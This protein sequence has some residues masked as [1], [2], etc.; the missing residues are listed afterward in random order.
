[1]PRV[2]PSDLTL[3][4]FKAISEE[5]STREI[6]QSVVL[7]I[8]VFRAGTNSV[9]GDLFLEKLRKSIDSLLDNDSE[10]LRIV[11]VAAGDVRPNQ[12]DLPQAIYAVALTIS[13][14]DV[15]ALPSQR[16]H[17]D[18]MLIACIS[19]SLAST[20]LASIFVPK[21][22]AGWHHVLHHQQF[23][24]RSPSAY[25][26]AALAILEQKG[27]RPNLAHAARVLLSVAAMVGY[28]YGEGW[29]EML[30]KVA[31]MDSSDGET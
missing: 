15:A 19:P 8:L 22:L 25:V 2:E 13:E 14:E 27:T 17:R 4:A 24:L 12:R 11:A 6:L 28:Q 10:L 31:S 3:P 5:T 23:T 7:D 9:L 29:R 20:L 21:M 18:M 16:F 30:T 1:L 26:P